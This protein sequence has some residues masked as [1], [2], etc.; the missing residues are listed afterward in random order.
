MTLLATISAITLATRVILS[1]ALT[2]SL[3]PIFLAW[4]CVISNVVG[5]LIYLI[6]NKRKEVH[7]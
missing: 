1:F 5:I 7:V 2:D 3:G 6:V 4:A